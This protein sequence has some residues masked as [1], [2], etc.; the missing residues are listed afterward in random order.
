[1]EKDLKGKISVI[2]P[3]HNAEKYIEKAVQSVSQQSYTNWELILVENGS[4]DSSLKISREFAQKNEK[5]RLIEEKNERDWK[6]KECR[7]GSCVR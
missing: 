5:I 6:C 1:M 3:V 2:I 4:E 7:P